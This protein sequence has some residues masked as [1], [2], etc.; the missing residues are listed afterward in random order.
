MLW[1]IFIGRECREKLAYKQQ[2]AT[3]LALRVV[4]SGL[5]PLKAD[6]SRQAVGLSRNFRTSGW[7]AQL[8]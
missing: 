4:S 2:Y 7:L 3:L 6:Y 5:R 8:V 1:R